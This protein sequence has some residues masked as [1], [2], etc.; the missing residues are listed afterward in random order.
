MSSTSRGAIRSAHDYYITP[1]EDIVTFLRS[2]QATDGLERLNATMPVARILDPCAGGNRTAVD[3]LFKE[4]KYEKDPTG[5]P[6]IEVKA[7][8]VFHIP[9]TEPSYPKALRQVFGNCPTI[10]TMDIRE[11]SPAQHHGDFLKLQ[12][13][14]DPHP[15]YNLQTPD[16]IITN[17]P[18]DKA[19]Q[20]I[21]HSL[22]I[23]RPE[24]W[25]IMLLRLNFFGSAKR[26][27]FFDKTMPI[28]T[29]VHHERM[30]FTPDG[31]TDSIEYMHAIWQ[32]DNYP[33]TSQLKVI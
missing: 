9:P 22:R 29:F 15:D 5:G 6:D 31:G 12:T 11:D 3:W 4:G 30:G 25:V 17:P 27:A 8:V 18:F 32:R 2:L 28:W 16:I 26:K 13:E 14:F 1:T 23:V 10:D 33:T 7:P 20:V 24:G 21:R 19:L